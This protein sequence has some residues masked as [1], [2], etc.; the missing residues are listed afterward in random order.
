MLNITTP[1][2]LCQ[3]LSNET[4]ICPGM[5]DKSI[6][7]HLFNVTIVCRDYRSVDPD[8]VPRIIVVQTIGGP[9]I[10]QQPDDR[11]SKLGEDT[12]NGPRTI[13]LPIENV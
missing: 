4:V 12:E 9:V 2:V 13:D 3:F 1:V 10:L 8:S 7:S 5:R 6:V 11:L